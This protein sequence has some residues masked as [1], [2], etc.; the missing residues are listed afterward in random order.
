MLR[1]MFLSCHITWFI[2]THSGTETRCEKLIKMK[3]TY[4][5]KNHCI[6]LTVQNFSI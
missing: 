3:D 5:M 6:L 4:L 2:F 1:L